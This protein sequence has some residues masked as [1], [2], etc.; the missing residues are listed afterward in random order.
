[1]DEKI[2]VSE[3]ISRLNG[4]YEESDTAKYFKNRGYVPERG[5][6]FWRK[7]IGCVKKYKAAPLPLSTVKYTD[8]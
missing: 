8:A 6:S 1:M 3:R 2:S 7:Q 5:T 4:D